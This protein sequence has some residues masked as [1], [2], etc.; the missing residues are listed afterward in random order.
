MSHRMLCWSV[1]RCAN[2]D[3]VVYSRAAICNISTWTV[4][5]PQGSRAYILPLRS[6]QLS[7][8]RC[9]CSSIGCHKASGTERVPWSLTIFLEKTLHCAH[10]HRT[11]LNTRSLVSHFR[12]LRRWVD[13]CHV[14]VCI[15]EMSH[16]HGTLRKLVNLLPLIYIDIEHA[17]LTFHCQLH[18]SGHRSTDCGLEFLHI[19]RALQPCLAILLSK[20]RALN[21]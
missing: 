13:S 14:C 20:V 1:A 21:R 16:R 19:S 18:C 3:F 8:S 4:A 9:L 17:L 6:L 10:R 11:A 15:S 5:P 7:T 12:R 2:K